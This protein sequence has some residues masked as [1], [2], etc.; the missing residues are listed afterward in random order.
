LSGK[1]PDSV[2]QRR[3]YD[4]SKRQQSRGKILLEPEWQ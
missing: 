2:R 3:G 4:I 1:Q